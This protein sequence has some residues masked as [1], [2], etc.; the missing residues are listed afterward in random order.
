MTS[1]NINSWTITNSKNDIIEL[2]KGNT[3]K[4]CVEKNKI[5]IFYYDSNITI[6]TF[7][8]EVVNG[9][10]IIIESLNETE[11]NNLFDFIYSIS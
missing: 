11:A 8:I 3:E 7:T 5:L 1:L 6:Y 2:S 10:K 9:T 4:Y